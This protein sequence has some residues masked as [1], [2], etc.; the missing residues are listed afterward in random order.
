MGQVN[1]HCSLTDVERFAD[2]PVRFASGNESQH[3]HLARGQLN[4]RHAR[5]QFRGYGRRYPS[6]AFMHRA[7][8][9]NQ[10]YRRDV[11]QQICFRVGHERAIDVVV[12]VESGQYDENSIGELAPNF[13]DDLRSIENWHA[14]VNE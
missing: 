5:H 2:L 8:A 3:S 1:L 7:H 6:T 10:I 13:L 11:F 12:G 4:A 9:R 14:K